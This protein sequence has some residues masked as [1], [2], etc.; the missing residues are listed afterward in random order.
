VNVVGLSDKENFL[1]LL[2]GGMSL[3]EI[4]QHFGKMNQAPA[5]FEINSMK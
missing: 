4:G 3:V 2:K 5:V 1:D